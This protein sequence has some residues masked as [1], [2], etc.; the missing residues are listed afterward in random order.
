MQRVMN[1]PGVIPET[2]RVGDKI[3]EARKVP[4]PAKTFFKI[5][6]FPLIEEQSF[7]CPVA[8]EWYCHFPKDGRCFFS[9]ASPCDGQNAAL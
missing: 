5:F 2:F 8:N 6:S 9:F 4:G 3:M 7:R 1:F